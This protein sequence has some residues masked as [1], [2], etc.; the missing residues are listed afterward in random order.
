MECPRCGGSLTTFTLA[1]SRATVCESCEYVGVPADHRPEP[2]DE[3]ESWQ[4]ALERFHDGASDDAE[5]EAEDGD[6]AAD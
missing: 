1:G 4:E 2:H 5:D 3:S 6:A